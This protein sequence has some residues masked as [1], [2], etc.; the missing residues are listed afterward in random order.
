MTRLLG[1]R[2]GRGVFLVIGWFSVGPGCLGLVL[3]LLPTT[4][5]L[6][7]AAWAFGR[8]SVRWQQ[9]LRHHPRFGTLIRGWEDH[10]VIPPWA[11]GAASVAIAGSF[12]WLTMSRDWPLWA[13]AVMA[14]LLGGV[15]VWIVSRPSRR[16]AP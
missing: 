5:L 14:G 2:P 16:P 10:R 8:R 3:P 12:A 9:W 4:P 6:L 13:F 1:S 7:L 11:K 15:L